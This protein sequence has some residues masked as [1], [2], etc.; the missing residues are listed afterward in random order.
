MERNSE[1]QR[2][3]RHVQRS[4][5][6]GFDK[7]VSLNI[8][9]VLDA[10]TMFDNSGVDCPNAMCVQY[11][12]TRMVRH[13]RPYTIRRTNMYQLY[14]TLQ[15]RGVCTLLQ[16]KPVLYGTVIGDIRRRV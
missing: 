16:A 15:E 10:D 6:S 1:C 12:D 8:N 2:Y 4:H 9:N 7:G 11:M 5:Y 14:R 13:H 3:F